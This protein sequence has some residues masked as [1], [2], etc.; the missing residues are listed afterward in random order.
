MS[1]AIVLATY[2]FAVSNQTVPD[3]VKNLPQKEREEKEAYI[4]KY[5]SPNVF[6]QFD[7]HIT[8]AWDKVDKNLTQM[9]SSLPFSS[10]SYN[11]S[12]IG[13]GAVG[14]HGTVL[15]QG[16]WGNFNITG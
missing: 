11:V 5:G 15:R 16:G 14:P 8:L 12:S 4:K 13:L 1:N 3:W 9:I 2:Q 7:P 10:F 6:S